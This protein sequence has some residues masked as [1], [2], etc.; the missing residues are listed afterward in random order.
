VTF[1]LERH[2]VGCVRGRS[3]ASLDES[4]DVEVRIFTA[5][6]V[7]EVHR[8]LRAG[9]DVLDILDDACDKHEMLAGHVHSFVWD[10]LTIG[11][12]GGE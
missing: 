10:T 5:Q 8:D 3:A 6:G 1:K 12:D 7:G 4:A 9:V 11:T 2:R